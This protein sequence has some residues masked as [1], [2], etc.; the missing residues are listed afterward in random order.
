MLT[1]QAVKDNLEN[2]INGPIYEL[3]TDFWEEIRAP[4]FQ[5][6]R[7]LA[8][9]CEKVLNSG[10]NCS[11]TEIGD[12]MKV[13]QGNL[14]QFTSDY[15]HRLFRDINT[16]LLRK[17]SKLFKKDEN[18]KN[19]EWR[20]I[21]EGKIR[22]LWSQYKTVMSEVVNDFKYIRLPK[23]ALTDALEGASK[24]LKVI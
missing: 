24:Y 7:D 10:F 16:N 2:I 14:C 3:N 17:F 18:G 23:N 22:E 13:L 5:E 9:N 20:D 21:E 15:I 11:D 4:Y 1:Q 12:F 19:R 8:L 6:M